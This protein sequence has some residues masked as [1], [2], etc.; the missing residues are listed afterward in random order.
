MGQLGFEQPTKGQLFDEIVHG[1]R[2]IRRYS[3][4]PIEKAILDRLLEAARWAPSAHN[5]QPWRFCMVTSVANKQALSEAM[6]QQWER[7]LTT[8]GAD[9]ETVERRVA[10]SRMRVTGAAAL[11]I[12]ALSMEE[13]DIYPDDKRNQAEWVMAV[14]STALA[15]EN[16]LLA[17]HSYGLGACWMC[18][19]LFVPDLVRSV[20]NLPESWQPQALIT[21]GYPS[22][23][24]VKTRE[25]IESRVMWR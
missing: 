15:C 6:G 10:I 17:A 1:R 18:A 20:L 12:A 21:L 24:K 2:S 19:P 9:R 13:M 4:R 5:R 8:D 7:D 3:S 23:E 25:P 16:L 11:L 22:E 14:Q